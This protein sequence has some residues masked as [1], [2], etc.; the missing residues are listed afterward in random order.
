MLVLRVPEGEFVTIYDL[1]DL[2][3]TPIKI[4]ITPQGSIGIEANSRYSIVR[5]DAT[6]RYPKI[7]ES[8]T[9]GRRA[10]A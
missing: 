3:A 7:A 8:Q 1:V 6:K 5:S 9:K 4:V 10:K 2:Q